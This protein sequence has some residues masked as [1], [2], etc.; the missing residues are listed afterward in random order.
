[1]DKT[2]LVFGASVEWGSGDREGG[3]VQRLN[4][5]LYGK[6]LKLGDDFYCPIY[7]LGIPGNDSQ[8]LLDRMGNEIIVRK[9]GTRDAAIII[10]I[11]CNDSQF[12]NKEKSFRVP[13]ERFRENLAKL[14]SIAKEYTNEV[15]FVGIHAIDDSRVDP[16]PWKPEASYKMEYVKQYNEII[17][18]FCREREMPF[19][20]VLSEFM[21]TDYIKMFEDGVH[22]NPEGHELIFRLVRDCLEKKGII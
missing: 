3:W 10:A 16:I 11:G 4:K 19:V 15:V 8:D 20:D 22:P 7:N 14:T 6:H 17:Q 18:E 21:K 1:M 2:I 12:N 9:K 5:H 13:P